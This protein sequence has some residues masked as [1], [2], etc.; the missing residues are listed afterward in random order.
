LRYKYVICKYVLAE[1]PTIY[2]NDIEKTVGIKGVD[3]IEA[4]GGA[5][6]VVTCSA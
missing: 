4:P 5:C 3:S 1:E 2:V 6:E